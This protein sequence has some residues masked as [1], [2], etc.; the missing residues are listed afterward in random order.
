MAALFRS[1]HVQGP[2]L[3]AP[4]EEVDYH[5]TGLAFIDDYNMGLA[6]IDGGLL[7]TQITCEVPRKDDTTA[8]FSLRLERAILK[9]AADYDFF[10]KGRAVRR[11]PSLTAGWLLLLP[12]GRLS[13]AWRLAAGGCSGSG[14]CWA[15]ASK[16]VT[17]PS[18]RRATRADAGDG[19]GRPAERRCPCVLYAPGCL[20]PCS[21]LAS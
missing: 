9:A 5:D 12:A 18:W 20:Q 2:W 15:T 13:S 3:E 17:L 21:Q 11:S 19:D 4:Q 1:R 14:C 8:T 10:K 16:S 7:V 6:F